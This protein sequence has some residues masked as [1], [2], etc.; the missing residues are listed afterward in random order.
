MQE[1]IL[2]KCDCPIE[3]TIK[4]DVYNLVPGTRY[5]YRILLLNNGSIS[6]KPDSG[7]ILAENSTESVHTFALISQAPNNYFLIAVEVTDP[8]RNVV[9]REVVCLKKCPDT[10]QCTP[11]QTPTTTPTPTNTDQVY[12]P[13]NYR[14]IGDLGNQPDAETGK[15]QVSYYYGMSD[16][17]ITVGQW[18]EF[19]NSVAFYDDPYSLWKSE[20]N[21]NKD[22]GIQQKYDGL[23]YCYSIQNCS[24][25]DCFAPEYNRPM[26]YLTWFDVARYCN[27]LHNNKKSGYPDASTTEDGAYS[28]YGTTTSIISKNPGAKFWIPSDDEWYKAAY[29]NPNS[30]K[31]STY[32]NR[33]DTLPGLPNINNQIKYFIDIGFDIPEGL[34]FNSPQNQL[35]VNI[36]LEI[37]N[38]TSSNDTIKQTLGI[39]NFTQDHITYTLSNQVVL[40]YFYH[41]GTRYY[42]LLWNQ[43]LATL[44]EISQNTIDVNW[45]RRINATNMPK[46]ML[47]VD[48]KS[49]SWYGVK[50]TVGNVREW[51]DTTVN[52]VSGNPSAVSIQNIVRQGSYIDTPLEYKNL[53][54]N[55]TITSLAGSYNEF[56]GGRIAINSSVLTNSNI[57]KTY[58]VGGQFHLKNPSTNDVVR[59]W[60][61]YQNGRKKSEPT[62]VST[63]SRLWYE[64]SYINDINYAK[65]QYPGYELAYASLELVMLDSKNRVVA[66]RTTANRDMVDGFK[67][68]PHVISCGFSL[69]IEYGHLPDLRGDITI[70]GDYDGD[71][72]F[73][74]NDISL[75]ESGQGSFPA[76]YNTPHNWVV[77]MTMSEIVN[78]NFSFPDIDQN[79]VVSLDDYMEYLAYDNILKYNSSEVS[80]FNGLYAYK[81]IPESIIVTPTPSPTNTRT[82]TTT[83]TLTPTKTPTLSPTKTVTK[84]PTNTRTATKTPGPT[85]SVTRTSTATPTPT[86]TTTPTN[87]PSQTN[88]RTPTQTPTAT[89]TPTVSCSPT[90]TPSNTTT[91]TP[92]QS[93]T[94]TPEATPTTT[95]TPSPTL[96]RTPTVTPSVSSFSSN[97]YVWGDNSISQLSFNKGQITEGLIDPARLN[98]QSR[99]VLSN[100]DNIV[101]YT[102]SGYASGVQFQS[103]Q[104]GLS[105]SGGIDILGNIHT[106]GNNDWGQLGIGNFLTKSQFVQIKTPSGT[107][108]EDL[109]LGHSH[110]V[111]LDD[112]GSI[113]TWG[114]NSDGQLGN[115]YLHRPV[116]NVSLIDADQYLYDVTIYGECINE[117]SINDTI[118]ISY[119]NGTQLITSTAIVWTE[120]TTDTN[121]TTLR[122]LWENYSDINYSVIPTIY[123]IT[124]ETSDIGLLA[125]PSPAKINVYKEYRYCIDKE[126]SFYSTPTPTSTQTRTPTNTPTVTNTVTNTT[127]PEPTPTPTASVTPT[128]TVTPSITPSNTTTIN[129]TPT[130]TATP[131]NTPSV[132]A[133]QMPTSTPTNT[134]TLTPSVTASNTPSLSVTASITPTSTVT[135]TPTNT[136][137]VTPTKEV[138]PVLNVYGDLREIITNDNKH[139]CLINILGQDSYPPLFH[140]VKVLDVQW[141]PSIN[142]TRIRIDHELINSNDEFNVPLKNKMQYISIIKFTS[143]SPDETNLSNEYE[144]QTFSKVYASESHTYAMD[145]QGRIYSCGS[146]KYGQL[147]LG[148]VQKVNAKK[149]LVIENGNPVTFISIV[150][151]LTMLNPPSGR[152]YC[153]NRAFRWKKISLGRFHVVA[154]DNNHNVWLWGDN[155]FG[156]IGVSET[157]E[158]IYKMKVL[159]SAY[160]PVGTSAN[161]DAPTR[162]NSIIPYAPYPVKIF[163]IRDNTSLANVYEDDIWLDIA[164]GAYHNLA[165]KQEFVNNYD[166][167]SLWGWGDNTFSQISRVTTSPDIIDNQPNT[168]GLSQIDFGTI[169]SGIGR[170]YWTRV[171]ASRITSFAIKSVDGRMYSWGESNR[172]QTGN[173]TNRTNLINTEVTIPLPLFN[174]NWNVNDDNSR[175]NITIDVNDISNVGFIGI[176]H[177]AN[178]MLVIPDRFPTPTPTPSVTPSLTP[179]M[180]NT[181]TN[182]ST[183]TN[184]ASVT[185]TVTPT[186]S[187]TPTVTPTVTN[188]PSPTEPF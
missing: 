13:L 130:A 79:G 112:T 26:R 121:T 96:T 123:S 53:S 41:E 185:P 131:T 50:D 54:K 100:F 156:Q 99:S 174:P 1:I 161:R 17:E 107:Y 125:N 141:M 98:E 142:T 133:T 173:I 19:L 187:E 94:P 6:F 71:K 129:L 135:S 63:S 149:E 168:I 57:Y 90:V 84:T 16:K 3:I 157:A 172:G 46:S 68:V 58:M 73:T 72:K 62:L 75:L 22:I 87:T 126:L 49:N 30:G 47:G 8:F 51:T 137:T 27:W 150:P 151:R 45:A 102:R 69:S 118:S 25:I 95:P 18:T 20:M 140:K 33:S 89:Q 61:G 117:F 167:G 110:S 124:K 81:I 80:V 165:I 88:T 182:T 109:S 85:A 11:T 12:N 105:M 147:G 37:I 146:N 166:Y 128:R 188:T 70:F 119:Y 143:D 114:R 67:L 55:T 158:A 29:Y 48:E 180:T 171:F 176:N 164:A 82:P 56:I 139:R 148:L 77:S 116:S 132:S 21:D 65:K 31:Y 91:N 177:L 32:G 181:P 162:N 115:H 60:P 97:I 163:V 138:F 170:N 14:F 23:Y 5:D 160:P 42:V 186:V 111:A 184:T 175:G 120:P 106:V 24:S 101:G 44:V 59:L 145:T 4:V 7:V 10:P 78:N 9:S 113:W 92:T 127:T 108:F 36:V 104:A 64:Y 2:E 86:L 103:I 34:D 153:Y 74:S 52:T 169:D 144:Y 39:T 93:V 66:Y 122:V 154:L 136:P 43:E 155:G 83:P 76:G 159:G 40:R 35:L 134:R 38:N 183:V 152:L 179:T 178:H 28:L 15:G